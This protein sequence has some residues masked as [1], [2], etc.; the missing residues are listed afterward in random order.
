MKQDADGYREALAALVPQ[1][2]AF[3][4]FLARDVTRADDLVQDALVRALERQEAWIPGTDLRAWAFR[5]LRNLFLDQQRRHGVEKRG[6]ATIT[7]P[8]HAPATQ[9]GRDALH[10]LDASLA[11]LPATQREALILVAAMELD[12]AEAAAVIGVPEGTVKAR[13]SRARATLARDYDARI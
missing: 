5:L 1:L 12:V 2:R 10:D 9:A 8:D 4:R 3:A 6:L 11:A 13:V 7:P